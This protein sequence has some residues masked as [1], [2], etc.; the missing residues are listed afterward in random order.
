[1]GDHT[2][3][4]PREWPLDEDG[5]T[6]PWPCPDCGKRWCAE[7]TEHTRAA[8]RVAFFDEDD[9]VGVSQARWVE[10]PEC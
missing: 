3:R 6:D 7:L 8:R 5:S 10:C 4:L 9:V 2:C 1:M